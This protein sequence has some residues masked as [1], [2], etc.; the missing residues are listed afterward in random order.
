MKTTIKSICVLLM[1]L[2]SYPLR[3]QRLEDLGQKELLAQL[4]KVIAQKMDYR[5][6]F[7]AHIDSMKLDALRQ[8]AEQRAETYIN[9]YRAY[10]N[11]QTDS[12]LVYLAKIEKLP[13]YN[14]SSELRARVCIGRAE[15]YGVMGL[16]TS[17]QKTLEQIDIQQYPDNIRLFYY[18]VCRK[19]Y[20]W[21]SDYGEIYDQK[22]HFR[23]LTQ[24]C[25][26]SILAIQEPS[27]NRS[28]VAADK[29]LTIGDINLAKT[30]C[31]GS[32]PQA[33]ELQR[34][35]I[36]F[37][38]SDIAHTEQNT[39]EEIRYLAMTAINDFKR[40]V[41]EY[42]ALPK[43][44]IILSKVGDEGRAYEYIVCTMSD[45]VYCKARLR[46][47]EAT[48]IFPI[49]EQNHKKSIHDRFVYTTAA[50]CAGAL[51]LIAMG[52][53][54]LL[55]KRRNRQ[56]AEMH[57][58]LDAAIAAQREVN[59]ALTDAN[60]RLRQ[61]NQVKGTYIARYLERCRTYIDSME[62]NRKKV[63]KML[64]NNKQAELLNMLKSD[65]TFSEEEALFYT[66]F[67]EAFLTLF[68]NF[69]S[70]F[71]SLLQPEAQ[72][73]TKHDE[74]LNTELR[75]FAL[76]RLGISDSNRIAHFLN[77]SLPTIYSYRSRLRNKS[78]YS[79]EEFE[80]KI[81]EC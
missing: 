77:Y 57:H 42:S 47:I 78:L 5:S 58:Q 38:M 72:I 31:A 81:M 41:T 44:A 66:D 4:D 74:M 8:P 3:A 16:Y 64:K 23:D 80:K 18:Q 37:T 9:I 28:I 53:M 22:M 20:G 39:E 49:I 26:D 65:P 71:N 24:L 52:I 2:F 12:A 75:I 15:I 54:L 59:K 17:A 68:P 35:Y 1:L 76:I 33:D 6:Q 61:A 73:V 70:N 40:G 55:A 48:T 67:D 21:M 56:L 13:I 11:I 10:S 79:K 63:L 30:I 32:L 69:V 50:L 27:I 34:A 45:A 7:I 60:E 29:A 46:T 43:L 25:R 36:Y 62:Q 51:F 14:K 19:L